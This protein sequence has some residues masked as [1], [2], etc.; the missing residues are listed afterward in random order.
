[1]AQ[2]GTSP[3]AGVTPAN[4]APAH[5]AQQRI[6]PSCPTDGAAA[7]P[8]AQQ[9]QQPGGGGAPGTGASPTPGLS[10]AEAVNEEQR[11]RSG[12]RDGS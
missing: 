12:L 4:H 6:D 9:P 7:Q 5:E 3:P 10:P 2:Q 8:Q 11:K 1:M